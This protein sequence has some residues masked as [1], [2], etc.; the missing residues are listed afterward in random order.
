[1]ILSIN[2]LNWLKWIFYLY[3]YV[4]KRV[5]WKQARLKTVKSLQVN[6][7]EIKTEAKFWRAD[8]LAVA[9]NIWCY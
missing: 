9:L 7:Q 3:I 5:P 4:F 8:Q 2:I 1:M 6:F